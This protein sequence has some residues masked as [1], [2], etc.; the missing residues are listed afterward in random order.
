MLDGW[1]GA[2]MPIVGMTAEEMAASVA[3]PFVSH[4]GT[5]AYFT[6]D[7]RRLRSG[8]LKSGVYV[9]VVNGHA[10]KTIIQ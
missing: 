7:G 10:Q 1:E 8:E 5:P 3:A 2:T 9:R 6:L 4:D